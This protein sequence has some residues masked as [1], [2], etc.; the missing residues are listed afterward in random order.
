MEKSEGRFFYKASLTFTELVVGFPSMSVLKGK[1]ADTDI[2]TVIYLRIWE[3]M[4][5]N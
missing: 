1:C 3:M 2:S 4:K 5:S